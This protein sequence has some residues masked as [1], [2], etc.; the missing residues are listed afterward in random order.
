MPDVSRRPENYNRVTCLHRI[1]T[2]R[3]ITPME[4]TGASDPELDKA[5]ACAIRQ[6]IAE[7]T[8]T[9]AA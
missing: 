9:E 8:E 2:L 6:L 7:A 3:G 1:D 5:L 4:E